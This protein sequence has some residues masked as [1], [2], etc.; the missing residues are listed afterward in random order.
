MMTRWIALAAFALCAVL[1]SQA[2]APAQSTGYA[3][4]DFISAGVTQGSPPPLPGPEPFDAAFDRAA[5]ATPAP[6]LQPST[7]PG[8]VAAAVAPL[9]RSLNV[10]TRHYV[11]GNRERI[12]NLT[13]GTATIRDC[14][15][16]TLT[17]L[18]LND[19]T[20]GVRSLDPS[21]SPSPAPSASPASGAKQLQLPKGFPVTLKL[22]VATR[23][24]GSRTID[25]TPMDG[26]GGTLHAEA[27]SAP[28]FVTVDGVLSEYLLPGQVRGVSCV[29]S[30]VPSAPDDLPP[31]WS[32]VDQWHIALQFDGPIPPAQ[33]LYGFGVVRATMKLPSLGSKAVAPITLTAV[34][35]NGHFRLAKPEDAT[36]FTIPE[37]FQP[38]PSPSP[39]PRPTEAVK[40]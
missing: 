17:T 37:G 33:R 11:L 20:Y 35:Q 23:A 24:L 7:K 19:K 10:A 30:I 34:S 6:T 13:L 1:M 36:L 29:T 31:V 18:N 28:Y 40:S 9:L 27:G 4:D 12:D 8:N 14:D 38:A 39:E 32:L 21:P 15:A 22:A 2:Q 26:F 5:K 16:R 3:Y 25:A